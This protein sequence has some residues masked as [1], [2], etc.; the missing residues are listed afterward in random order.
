VP[1]RP[2][3]PARPAPRT[4][5]SSPCRRI[6][7]TSAAPPA[8]PR[9]PAPAPSRGRAPRRAG[10][11]HRTSAGSS[12]STVTKSPGL[13][14]ARPR[15]GQR[16]AARSALAHRAG[17]AADHRLGRRSAED[18]QIRAP[19]PGDQRAILTMRRAYCAVEN[20]ERH[21]QR[22]IVD[23]LRQ[24]LVSADQSALGGTTS[25]RTCRRRPREGPRFR[26]VA[27]RPPP[28]R[29][30]TVPARSRP[31]SPGLG[32]RFGLTPRQNRLFGGG[33]GEFGLLDGR[34]TSDTALQE[35]GLPLRARA[36]R[37]RLPTCRRDILDRQT[38]RALAPPPARSRHRAGRCAPSQGPP[39]H[40]K[41]RSA[42]GR[43]PLTRR[44]PPRTRR[45]VR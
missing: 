4:S 1:P 43:H 3:R 23:Q 36:R 32:L 12:T 16:A 27:A 21:L 10:A 33:R 7:V 11:P 37:L 8:G 20:P 14:A 24:A 28:G 44:R 34:G 29:S 6:S 25:A 17:F 18:V 35:V 41:G 26:P 31:R 22:R 13:K 40:P 2:R 30:A 9:R 38:V 19:A 5:T 39:P 45:R 15:A 42:A